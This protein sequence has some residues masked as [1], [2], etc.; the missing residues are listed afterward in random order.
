MKQA[1]CKTNDKGGSKEKEKKR[2]RWKEGTRRS[3]PP[4][5]GKHVP[6]RLGARLNWASV[7]RRGEAGSHFHRNKS[8]GV[9][10]VVVVVGG[11]V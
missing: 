11:S 6:S 9:A 2:R 4:E 3:A 5:H 8:E 10:V 1:A 7:Q